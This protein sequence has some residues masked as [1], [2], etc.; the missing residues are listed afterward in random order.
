MTLTRKA[1]L[2]IASTMLFTIFS[3]LLARELILNPHLKKIE[4]AADLRDVDR[5]EQA[6]DRYRANLESRIGRIY[7]AAGLLQ[8]LEG[9]LDWSPVILQLAHIGGYGE[10]DYFILADESGENR[11]VKAGEIAEK[12][13]HLPD[14]A[15]QVEI[16]NE[17][18]SR[19]DQQGSASISGLLLSEGDGPL[20]YAAGRANWT[21][22]K[23]PSIYCGAPYR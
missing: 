23:L 20:I 5:F 8:G 1:T 18:V 13:R 3:G 16:F 22:D 10:L 11:I 9:Q 6:V 21:T 12:T 2:I 15:T 14:N 17:A 19:L 4:N 7:A